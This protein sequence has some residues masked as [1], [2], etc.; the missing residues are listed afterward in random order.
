MHTTMHNKRILTYIIQ[1]LWS[2]I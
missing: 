2:N 1:C